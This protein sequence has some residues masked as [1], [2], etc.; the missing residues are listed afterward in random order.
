MALASQR[1]NR[2]CVVM[3]NADGVI[4]RLVCKEHDEEKVI[5]L[6]GPGKRRLA[7][8]YASKFHPINLSR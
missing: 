8:L 6:G 2:L 7:A 3:I 4:W 1:N 5:V